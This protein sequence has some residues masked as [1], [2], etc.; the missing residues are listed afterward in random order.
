MQKR[1]L[2]SILASCIVFLM[3]ISTGCVSSS[4]EKTQNTASVASVNLN[5][6]LIDPSNADLWE[7][8][9]VNL[10][11]A[12]GESRTKI[13]GKISACENIPVIIL[14]ERGEYIKISSGSQKG[15]VLKTTVLGQ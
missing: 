3:I 13:T 9:P 10:W 6:C 14:D 5:V 15:W 4:S 2:L 11:D 12:P 8:T 1:R 7:N